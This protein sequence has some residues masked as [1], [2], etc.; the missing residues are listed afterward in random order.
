MKP[1]TVFFLSCTLLSVQRHSVNTH[2]PK[3]RN[4]APQGKA[5]PVKFKT[6]S[7][8]S[9]LISGACAGIIRVLKVL[10]IS[11]LQLCCLQTHISLSWPGCT[12][13]LKL[14]STDVPWLWHLQYSGI[15]T[16][17]ELQLHKWPFQGLLVGH[18]M[19]PGLSVSLLKILWLA[20]TCIFHVCKNI[21]MHTIL[22]N[23][24]SPGFLNDSL[25]FLTLGKLSWHMLSR[26]RKT[27]QMPS[28]HR[29]H[30]FKL[31]CI[32]TV[33]AFNEWSLAVELVGQALRVL[34]RTAGSQ[35]QFALSVLCRTAGSQEQSQPRFF[36][37]YLGSNFELG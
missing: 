34:C 4:Q 12:L 14:S 33:G 3:G 8:S 15:S 29:L 19:M 11:T 1:C 17:T 24:V 10:G 20:Q 23:S 28:R 18:D 7:W 30:S 22:L 35:S 2:V 9:C 37:T 13:C 27:L 5:E 36:S 31:L 16:V 6:T 26:N 32:F 21:T 25:C